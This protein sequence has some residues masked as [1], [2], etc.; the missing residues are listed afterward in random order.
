[1]E[2]VHVHSG[3]Q[4]VARF[5]GPTYPHWALQTGLLAGAVPRLMRAGAMRR[6]TA[7]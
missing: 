3:G 1:V 4:A 7:T 6:M 2:H 5:I